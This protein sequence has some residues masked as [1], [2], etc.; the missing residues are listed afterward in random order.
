MNICWLRR[1]LRLQDNHALSEATLA[2]ETQ[3]VFVFDTKIL[4]KLKNKN[5]QRVSFIYD[6]LIEIEKELQKRGSSLL[7]LYGDPVKEIPAIA[8]KLKAKALYFNRDYEPY[9]KRR[10]GAVT[11]ALSIPVY[12]Y[13][14]TVFFEKE[15]V[16]ALK[17]FGAYKRRW[18]EKFHAISYF[19]V[20]SKNFVAFKNPESILSFN[21]YKKI[22]FKETTPSLVAGR[23]AGLK[24]L[25]NFLSKMYTYSTASDFPAKE[26]NSFLSVYLRFGNL[27]IREVIQE[28]SDPT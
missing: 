25:K 12:S 28:A 4:N 19:K 26:G 24:R 1:D 9:A 27:S 15:D 5:D 23:K 18:L 21:W 17:V 11:Q 3:I 16:P 20:H 13:K 2:G 22:G 7:I 8:K 14:D 10:D 6:S